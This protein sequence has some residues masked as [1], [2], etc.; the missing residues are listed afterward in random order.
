M[1]VQANRFFS[2][3]YTMCEDEHISGR[4]ETKESISRSGIT[5]R[6]EDT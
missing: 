3:V 5:R 4:D 2:D 6:G 1:R